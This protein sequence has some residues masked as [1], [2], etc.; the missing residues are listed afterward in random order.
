[1]VCQYRGGHRRGV[2]RVVG[3]SYLEEGLRLRRQH[4]QLHAV[5]YLHGDSRGSPRA[6]PGTA[7]PEYRTT[8]SKELWEDRGRR[9]REEGGELAEGEEE[10]RYRKLPPQT[11]PNQYCFS[12]TRATR[13]A[14][15]IC[16]AP[17]PAGTCA[18]RHVSTGRRFRCARRGWYQDLDPVWY[19][20]LV[21]AAEHRCDRVHAELV[22]GPPTYIHRYI[23]TPMSAPTSVP[24]HSTSRLPAQ[25]QQSRGSVPENLDAVPGSMRFSYQE[26]TAYAIR[27]HPVPNIVT[28]SVRNSEGACSSGQRQYQA[29]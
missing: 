9:D 18:V 14:V 8:L 21:S 16:T 15:T 1:M 28:V 7:L 22:L 19:K 20:A 23:R 13:H 10:G 2:G 12:H 26:T 3:T 4:D 29:V 25:C 6:I 24:P 5:R 27:P 11:A 17:G